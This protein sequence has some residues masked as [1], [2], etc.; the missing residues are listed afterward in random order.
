MLFEMVG[1]T[2]KELMIADREHGFSV[3]YGHIDLVLGTHARG[4][5]YPRIAKWIETH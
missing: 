3:D 2:E 4:E 1:S 5:I